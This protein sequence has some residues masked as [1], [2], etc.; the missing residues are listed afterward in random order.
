MNLKPLKHTFFCC[1]ALIMLSSHISYAHIIKKHNTKL[2]SLL[3]KQHLYDELN[4]SDLGLKRNIFEKALEGWSKLNDQQKIQKSNLLSILD[5]SQS[6]NAKRLYVIDM[7]KR[8]VVFNTYAAHGKKSGGEFARSFANK[9]NSYKSSL[10]FYLTGETY[11]G[12]HGLSMRLKGIEKGINDH[13]ES[14][15]IVMHGAS[16]VSES[17]MKE[18]GRLGRSEGCPAVPEELCPL[19]VNYI[20]EG[21]CLYLYYPDKHYF[22]KSNLV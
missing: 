4:L 20:K 18:S 13:A 15:G 17:F 6:S 1:I 10:G 5:L 12:S 9:N 19:I 16:Y 14:R 3:E 22:K 11:M 21:S 2:S 7:E 8:E